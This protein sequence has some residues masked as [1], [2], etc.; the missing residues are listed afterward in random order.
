MLFQICFEINVLTAIN[1]GKKIESEIRCLD[2]CIFLRFGLSRKQRKQIS[3]YTFFISKQFIR[4]YR[5]DVTVL[6]ISE[7]LGNIIN[8]EGKS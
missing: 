4:S 3:A 6:R 7:N 8:F 5:S 1:I 2:A